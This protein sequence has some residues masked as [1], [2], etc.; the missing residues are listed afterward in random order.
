MGDESIKVLGSSQLYC[1][2]CGE[3]TEC[4]AIPPE[5]MRHPT[6]LRKYPRDYLGIYW[7]RRVRM[8]LKCKHK[9]M[10]AEID[11][12]KLVNLINLAVLRWGFA[13]TMDY[14]NEVMTTEDK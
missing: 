9:F 13:Y 5:L 7:H 11:E 10:T 3:V 6:T 4:L 14:F 1:A 8:C 2:Q 12:E